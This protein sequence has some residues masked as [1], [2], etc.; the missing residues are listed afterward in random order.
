MRLALPLL[1]MLAVAG[2][3]G[4]ALADRPIYT[5]TIHDHQ[6]QPTELQ[7]PAGQKI[8]LHVINQDPSVEEFESTDMHR[9]K[10]VTGGA[11]I[12]VYIGPLS[13]GSYV[14]FGD[15]HPDSARGHIVAK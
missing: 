9:E 1:A 5:L 15:F 11:Q 6:F 3:A 2:L 4:T 12:T 10:I 14:F 8:V 7:V 13:P